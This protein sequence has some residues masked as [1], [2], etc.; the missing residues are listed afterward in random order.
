MAIINLDSYNSRDNDMSLLLCRA[1]VNIEYAILVLKLTCNNNDNDNNNNNNEIQPLAKPKKSN[2]KDATKTKNIK[3]KRQ[4]NN[5]V[6][7]R[8]KFIR[9]HL[10]FQNKKLIL[11][12]LRLNRDIIKN[13]LQK[14]VSIAKYVHVKLQ[15][16]FQCSVRRSIISFNS[17]PVPTNITFIPVSASIF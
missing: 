17:A 1:Y 2:L 12:E 5:Y 16:L 6:I 10:N 4:D 7:I 9:E 8:L 14:K 13:W 11:K 3:M 15:G